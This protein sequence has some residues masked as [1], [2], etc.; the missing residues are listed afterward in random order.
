LPL[1]HF[2][3]RA[4]L[5]GAGL[6]CA[7]LTGAAPAA[8]HYHARID[9]RGMHGPV[10]VLLPAEFAAQAAVARMVAKFLQGHDESLAQGVPHHSLP[11]PASRCIAI[12]CAPAEIPTGQR[13]TQP[14]SSL[15]AQIALPPC[16][17]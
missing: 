7:G 3:G 11:P 9:Q 2:S 8:R 4:V 13:P 6:T 17:P 5:A 14:P 10:G 12:A 1:R 16:Q 15:A